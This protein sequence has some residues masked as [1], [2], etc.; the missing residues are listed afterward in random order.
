M[1]EKL[2]T[3]RLLLRGWSLADFEPLAEFLTDEE[4]CKFRGGAV[5]R[6]EASNFMSMVTGQW[7]LRGHG[8]F[9]VEERSVGR[10]IGMTGLWHPYD[11]DEPELYWSIF[12]GF[13]GKG[14]ATEAAAAVRDWA[15]DVKK[16]S[17]MSFVSPENQ[18]SIKL[19]ERLGA[20]RDKDATLGGVSK[21]VYRHKI[22][23]I[24]H[25]VDESLPNLSFMPRDLALA[26]I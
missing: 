12:R 2:Q 1:I 22:I 18:P 24:G 13:H 5:S 10:V 8:G 25:P 15:I 11:F 6:I 19:A 17:I 16:I 20:Q 23:S 3:E 14:Y 26:F 9:A 4:L 21:R 7:V